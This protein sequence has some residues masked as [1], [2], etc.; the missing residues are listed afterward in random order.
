[1]ADPFPFVAGQILTA[2][3]LN[4]IEPQV[5]PFIGFITGSTYT[6]A[7]SS[8]TNTT[9]STVSLAEYSPIY[10]ST[11]STFDRISITSGTAVTNPTAVRLGIYTA[12]AGKPSALVLDA[13]T[14]NITAINTNYTITISQSL[15]VGWYFLV[16][17]NQ[18][19]ASVTNILQ[20]LGATT[21]QGPG[22]ISTTGAA[23][24]GFGDT[25]AGAFPAT[26]TTT[27]TRTQCIQVGLRKA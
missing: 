26:T 16:A 15:T 6:S 3:E 20:I 5:S 25:V 13:G 7:F 19:A 24:V 14:V 11:T 12:V 21:N 4:Q 10:I 1:M 2:A 18:T 9:A 22:K 23:Q 17:V 8:T 27:T